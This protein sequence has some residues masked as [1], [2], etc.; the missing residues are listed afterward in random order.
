VALTLA[1]SY[2]S[3][4]GY[5][6]AATPDSVSVTVANGD[7]LVVVGVVAT[8]RRSWIIPVVVA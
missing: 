7:Y 5:A 4:N 2:Q 1:A 3:A 8:R 6:A